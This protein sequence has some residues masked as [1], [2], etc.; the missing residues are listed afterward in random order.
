MADNVT[1]PGTGALVATDE[2]TR[3]AIVQHAQLFKLIFGGDGV[4]NG[5]LDVGQQA[6]AASIPVVLASNQ[7]AIPVSQSGTWNIGS[8]TSITNPVAVTGT[9]WQATQPISGT[10]TANIGTISTIATEATLS[11]LNGKVTACNTGAVTISSALPAGANVIG[12]VSIDQT[13]PGTTNLVAAGQSGTWS[14]TNVSGTVSLPTGAATAARQDTGNA[15]MALVADATYTKD[16]TWTKSH[17]L[18]GAVYDDVSPASV[19]ENNTTALRMTSARGLHVNLKTE[20]G[21]EIGTAGSPIRTDPT[22]STTQPVSGTVTANLAAGSNLVGKVGIDQTTPST[23]NAISFQKP[24]T[25][26]LSE[27]KIDFVATGDNT[28][29]AA[30]AAQTTR[31]HRIFFVVSADTNVTIKD[32]ATALT[33]VITMKAGG[34]FVLDMDGDPWFTGSTNTNFII[35]QSGTAQISGRMYYKQS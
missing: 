13:T 30:V 33:G 14:I 17:M 22:G 32:G 31:L 21:T 12:K 8:V 9:F 28:I 26:G 27:A 11:T 34:S 7:S 19:T 15:S 20:A 16:T 23:T 6:M 25:S 4:Y 1:L 5:M 3:A 2:I 10:V 18:I 29:V 35:N 24:T